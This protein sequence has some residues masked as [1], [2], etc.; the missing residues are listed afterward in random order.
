MKHK[1][2]M[3]TYERHPKTPLR[4]QWPKQNSFDFLNKCTK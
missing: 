1:I 3:L 4:L 2:Q